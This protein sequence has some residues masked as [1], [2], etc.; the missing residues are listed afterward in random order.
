MKGKQSI[1]PC[2]KA[3]VGAVLDAAPGHQPGHSRLS[4]PSQH[5]GEGEMVGKS[6]AGK[7]SLSEFPKILL[8]L[9]KL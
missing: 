6:K 1:L 4:I 9:R 5:L 7:S 3:E 8:F 2:M